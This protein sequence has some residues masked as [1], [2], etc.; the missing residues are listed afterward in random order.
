MPGITTTRKVL[1]QA[2][3][4]FQRKFQQQM[5]LFPTSDLAVLHL[6]QLLS[7]YPL[8]AATLPPTHLVE[9]FVQKHQLYP[10]LQAHNIPHP[11]TMNLNKSPIE[12]LLRQCTYPVFL[13]PSLSQRFF[14][15]FQQKGFLASS[16]REA[17]H[18]L[19]RARAHG[20]QLLLQE[21]I[22]GPSRHLIVVKGFIDRTGHPQIVFAA[23]NLRQPTPFLDNSCSVSIPLNMVQHVVTQTLRFL[24]AVQYH[25]LFLAE[26]KRD[27]RDQTLKLLEINPR[28]GGYNSHPI[29]CGVNPLLAAYHEAR[30][31]AVSYQ[32]TYKTPIF[33]IHLRSDVR[34]CLRELRGRTTTLREIIQT[35]RGSTHWLIY[36]SDDILPFLHQERS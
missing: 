3:Q 16:A 26:W 8:Y 12:P 28:C 15:H 20:F 19:R 27:A 13:K 6:T 30:D 34:S 9:A 2:L 18:Q 23:Q 29:A 1:G 32:S 7:E 21:F 11:R 35:Y 36:A 4:Q 14:H 24:K 17:Y 5:V 10:L 33:C 25:G 22:P 31:H